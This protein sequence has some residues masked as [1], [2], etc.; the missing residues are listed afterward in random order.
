MSSSLLFIVFL[1][2]RL[3]DRKGFRTALLNLLGLQET[4]GAGDGS[5]G[6]EAHSDTPKQPDQPQ[7]IK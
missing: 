1:I 7:E 6:K 5:Q 3:T 4:E 2:H